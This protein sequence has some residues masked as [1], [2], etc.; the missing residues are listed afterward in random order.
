M[1][2]PWLPMLTFLN[3]LILHVSKFYW[4]HLWMKWRDIDCN[5]QIEILILIS[6]KIWQS[7]GI[8]SF[9]MI[10]NSKLYQLINKNQ[11][12]KWKILIRNDKQY[13]SPSRAERL[14]DWIR[15]MQL[16]SVWPTKCLFRRNV[17]IRTTLGRNK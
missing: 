13:S 10:W 2:T 12:S 5:I 16:L 11:D 1:L 9:R 6:L 14:K 3:L 7:C 15:M 17:W 4:N 8:L